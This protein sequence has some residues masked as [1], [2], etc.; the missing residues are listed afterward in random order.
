MLPRK[1]LVNYVV[2]ACTFVTFLA[3]AIS[4]LVLFFALPGG[5]GMGHG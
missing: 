5:P 1:L 3:A 2:D 4:A